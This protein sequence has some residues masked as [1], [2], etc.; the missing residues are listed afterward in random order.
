[1]KEEEGEEEGKLSK[2]SSGGIYLETGTRDQLRSLAA[3]VLA[4]TTS[5]VQRVPIG[6]LGLLIGGFK[7]KAELLV[8]GKKEEGWWSSLQL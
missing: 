1:M 8:N 3:L 5:E 4:V 6:C 7:E 2:K